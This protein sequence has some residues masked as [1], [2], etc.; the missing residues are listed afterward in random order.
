MIRKMLKQPG[1]TF[2]EFCAVA[3]I[4]SIMAA[5]V[6][7][8]VVVSEEVAKTTLRDHYVATL[9]AAVERFHD[10]HGTWPAADLKEIAADAARFPDGLPTNPVS[11]GPFRLN[12]KTHEVE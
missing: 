10:E 4:V 6:V 7:P 11:G 12:P 8:R 3:T 5:I 2:I 9:N 1:F